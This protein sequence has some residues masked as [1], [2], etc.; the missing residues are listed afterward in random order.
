MLLKPSQSTDDTEENERIRNVIQMN[1]SGSPRLN[2]NT[3]VYLSGRR[4]DFARAFDKAREVVALED[5]KSDRD[6]ALSADQ[7]NDLNERLTKSTAQLPEL[8]KACYSVLH[9]PYGARDEFR[10]HDLSAAVKTQPNVLS[11]ATET[12]QGQD[13]LLSGLDPAL[14]VQFEPYK[15]WPS[16]VDTVDL[17]NLREYFERYPHLPMLE[18]M[19]VIK[20]SVIQGVRNNLFEAALKTGNAYTQV[21][22]RE[23]PPSEND[24]FFQAHYQLTRVGVVPRPV[25]VVDEDKPIPPGKLPDDGTEPPVKPPSRGR[26]KI[27]QRAQLRFAN[28]PVEQ[29][30]QLVDVAGAL[31]DA[32]GT[33]HIAVSIEATN[34]DGLDETALELNVRE[35]LSQYRLAVDWEES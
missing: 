13:R 31:Q 22:R 29:I 25:K 15:L 30:D 32:G 19:D 21:W 2:K 34:P 33:L 4:A 24:L 27:K 8:A 16:D 1:A 18:T 11:A 28:L 20:R 10:V 6:L 3:L 23:N 5:V 9:E 35:V 26:Q 14:L 12:L 17:K 7:K